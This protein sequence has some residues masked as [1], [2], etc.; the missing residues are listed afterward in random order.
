MSEAPPARDAAG[1]AERSEHG[2]AL[3]EITRLQDLRELAPQWDEVLSGSETCTPFLSHDW[4]VSWLETFGADHQPWILLLSDAQGVCGIAPLALSR[5]GVG[6]LRYRVLELIGTGPLRFL[7]MGLSDR[8]DLLL[9]RR[10]AECVGRVLEHLQEHRSRWDVMD[11]RFVPIDSTTV[12]L[13]RQHAAGRGFTYWQAVSD[14]SPYLPLDGSFEDYLRSRSANF[15]SGLKRKLK[16]LH[17]LQGAEFELDAGE[18]AP[19]RALEAATEVSL[20]SWKAQEGSALLLHRNVHAFLTRL[21]PRLQA[22]NG[23]YLSLLHVDGEPIAHELGFRFN[24]RLWFYDHAY[25]TNR[26]KLSPG[27]LLTAKIIERAWAEGLEEYDFLRGNENYKRGWVT[28]L[29]KELQVVVD[30]GSSKGR[31]A[32][33]VAFQGKNRLKQNPR[34]VELQGRMAGFLNKLRQ[35]RGAART[36]DGKASS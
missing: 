25:K 20:A 23:L 10:H 19:L 7:G 29:H 14:Y 30:N 13:L 17:A 31:L 22:R 21:L 27:Y 35:R 36:A 1:S 32:R 15:R 8:S 33:L 34:L 18:K 16:R 11:L 9:R 24:N 4:V 5:R 3:R 2:L 28:Q 6:P 12:A 26:G